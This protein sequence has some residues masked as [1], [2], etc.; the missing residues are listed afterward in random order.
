[1]IQFFILAPLRIVRFVVLA[2]LR[3]FRWALLFS[4][5]FVKKVIFPF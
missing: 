4:F 5:K 1:M 3:L 2:P